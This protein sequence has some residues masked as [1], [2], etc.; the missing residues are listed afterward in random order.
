[1]ILGIGLALLD[2]W[3]RRMALGEIEEGVNEG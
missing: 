2:I 3:Q 1:V